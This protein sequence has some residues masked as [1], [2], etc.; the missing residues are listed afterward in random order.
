[1]IP[2]SNVCVGIGEYRIETLQIKDNMIRSAHI[3][4]AQARMEGRITD[5]EES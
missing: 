1:M 2:E 5:A 4:R 3:W